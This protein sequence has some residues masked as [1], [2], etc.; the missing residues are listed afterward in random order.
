MQAVVLAA[1]RSARFK[2]KKTKQLSNICGQPMI[3]YSLD[4]LNKLDIPSLL[5]LGLNGEDV[6]Q[7]VE[8][9]D[10]ANIDFVVQ[11]EQLGSGH[12]VQKTTEKWHHD[13]ILILKGDIPLITTELIEF[14][15]EKHTSKNATVSFLTSYVLEP[16]GYGRVIEENGSVSIID[17]ASCKGDQCSVNRINAGIYLVERTFLQ[18]HIDCLEKNDQ[19]GEIPIADIV[20]IASQEG[21]AVQAITVPHDNVREVNTLEDL[22]K[23][24]QIKRSE[25]ISAWMA[26]GVR[27]ELAQNVYIE[28]GVTIE[29]GTFIGTGVHLLGN[30]HIGKDCTINAFTILENVTVGDNSIIHSHSVVQDATLATGVDIGPFAR[31]HRK[32]TVEEGGVIGNFVEVKNS[33][34]GKGTKAKHLTYLGDA[35]IGD[36]TNIGAGSITCNYDGEHKHRTTI[37]SKVF[38]GSN[39]TLVAPVSLEDSSYTAAGSTITRDVPSQTLAIAR[40]RQV[41]K[42]GY[43]DRVKSTQ[44]RS[45]DQGATK[46]QHKSSGAM[47]FSPALKA[48]TVDKDII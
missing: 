13:H 35:D 30:T 29:E 32:V 12:A 14:L 6:K 4:V 27:F 15:Y 46:M 33:T 45:I 22:W 2:T 26:K 34:I 23:V 44:S 11:S 7:E 19:T 25:L 31:V 10:F 17:E 24:Q 3:L 18:E 8:K 16:N 36:H 38:V 20:R 1:G 42:E 39:N 41:N 47:Q 28:L 5:V 21:K 37:G 48:K 43:L 40:E 9:R